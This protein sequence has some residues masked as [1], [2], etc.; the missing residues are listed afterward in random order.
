M[1]KDKENMTNVPAAESLENKVLSG[2][3]IDNVTWNGM[4][5]GTDNTPKS[6]EASEGLIKKQ[7]IDKLQRISSAKERGKY[8]QHTPQAKSPY[9]SGEFG[10]AR[11]G[12]GYYRPDDTVQ[13]YSYDPFSQDNTV[14]SV[15]S[16]SSKE[17]TVPQDGSVMTFGAAPSQTPR[18]VG[19]V[20]SIGHQ[21]DRG[22]TIGSR[23]NAPAPKP[24]A[25]EFVPGTYDSNGEMYMRPENVSAQSGEP[26]KYAKPNVRNASSASE[27]GG[28]FSSGSSG[29]QYMHVKSDIAAESS[30]YLKVRDEGE[31]GEISSRHTETPTIKSKADAKTIARQ[32]TQSLRQ[33]SGKKLIVSGQQAGTVSKA[34]TSPAKAPGAAQ[35]SAREEIA[36][37]KH[38]AT[39]TYRQTV[40]T[41][42]KRIRKTRE[43]F[44]ADSKTKA[45]TDA[46]SELVNQIQSNS[47]LDTTKRLES[48]GAVAESGVKTVKNEGI[49]SAQRDTEPAKRLNTRKK[50]FLDKQAT[51]AEAA[52]EP[53]A[54]V[55]KAGS[56]YSS[57]RTRK[58]RVVSTAK[59]DIT[60][61]SKKKASTEGTMKSK[62]T[63]REMWMRS[64][65]KNNQ[66]S[67]GFIAPDAPKG[68]GGVA[69]AVSA[70]GGSIG[71]II[72]IITIILSLI[73][74]ISTP[75]VQST[76]FVPLAAYYYTDGTQPTDAEALESKKDILKGIK[77]FLKLGKGKDDNEDEKK[78]LITQAAV[79]EMNDYMTKMKP[80]EFVADM[81]CLEVKDRGEVVDSPSGWPLYT[82]T[83]T[84]KGQVKDKSQ[85][86]ASPPL[87]WYT[88]IGEKYSGY[89]VHFHYKDTAGEERM[90]EQLLLTMDTQE[91]RA[92]NGFQTI[93]LPSSELQY[94]DQEEKY[95]AGWSS[96]PGSQYARYVP[97]EQL[98]KDAFDILC[99]TSGPDKI[100]NLYPVMKEYPT[101]EK[102]VTVDALN[103][104]DRGTYGTWITDSMLETKFKFE[105][106]DDS[107][108][109]TV[110][111]TQAVKPYTRNTLYQAI[112]GMATVASN[113]D[114]KHPDTY[115]EYCLNQIKSCVER[116]KG[117]DVNYTMVYLSGTAGT[118]LGYSWKEDGV[119]FQA[120]GMKLVPLFTVHVDADT[121][122]LLARDE[123]EASFF[124]KKNP[125]TGW[126][127]GNKALARAYLELDKNDFIELFRVALPVEFSSMADFAGSPEQAEAAVYAALRDLG[128]NHAVTCGIM[129]N[130]QAESGFMPN[131]LENSANMVW[132]VSDEEYTKRVIDGT[133]TRDDFVNQ[134]WSD[135]KG[136]E[137]L[138]GYGLVQWSYDTRK[139]GLYDFLLENGFAID[140]L[141][142]QI[143]YL[144]KELQELFPTIYKSFTETND[145]IGS[146]ATSAYIWCTQFEKP[147]D[148]ETSGLAR[149]NIAQ[150]FYQK[151][152]NFQDWDNVSGSDFYRTTD[153]GNWL[154]WPGI[155]LGMIAWPVNMDE[156][157]TIEL[158][159]LYGPRVHPITG[160]EKNHDGID[161]LVSYGTAIY[162]AYD[163]VVY[164]T[165]YFSKQLDTP[166][167]Y[168]EATGPLDG[169]GNCVIIYHPDIGLYTLYAH[170]SSVNVEVG[171]KV[172]A[173]E[174]VGLCGSTGYSTGPH[175]HFEVWEG[176]WQ[177]VNPEK[178]L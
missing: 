152:L 123:T 164:Q 126:D 50:L 12:G 6:A 175:L 39:E 106:K 27:N 79:N 62:K 65:Q 87:V 161:I 148:A 24:Q 95:L 67:G 45:K 22:N 144:D 7:E 140:S 151:Y 84:V 119:S 28:R 20:R 165:N 4:E 158:G 176:L 111:G 116:G 17:Q 56:G 114:Y 142:G 163:G 49:R 122:E 154:S 113:N 61:E 141:I 25:D 16:P 41:V 63:I 51:S 66:K 138:A 134:K 103:Y 157:G 100:V 149:G 135:E 55:N 166:D 118:D 14:Q 86:W 124:Y 46:G 85:L 156:G 32:H 121:E 170:L 3:A 162:S 94:L 13:T 102:E 9:V 127:S 155:G 117:Y 110:F 90:Y 52:R 137:H 177:R 169:Y 98:D 23:T 101:S 36:S 145:D 133:V 15:S 139:A 54:R 31:V 48:G 129:A 5:F 168:P 64:T 88:L 57:T 75:L 120:D 38:S 115:I 58:L 109:F 76:S 78:V 96:Y 19:Y 132:G 97:Y 150:S 60:A 18:S 107:R 143:R 172:L 178:Y 71:S 89:R 72:G 92:I 30:P 10:E 44:V 35:S 1:P 136:E 91:T 2:S 73:L 104:S 159:S 81:Q 112:L 125:F 131:N 42:N 74:G 171:Q 68:R 173:G 40:G 99:R 108:S 8:A 174:M 93:G 70:S 47:S 167:K 146:A 77:D 80:S 26:S 21:A 11:G 69:E 33:S 37:G 105:S 147:Q 29:G 153:N 82:T 160:E 34:Q 128:F 53:A 43:G 59:P 130:I 83:I